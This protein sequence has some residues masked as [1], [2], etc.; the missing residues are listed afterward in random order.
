MQ[1]VRRVEELRESLTQVKAPCVLVPTMGA[2]HEG[3]LSLVRMARGFADATN[4]KVVVSIFVN[5]IQFDREDDLDA[6][7]RDFQRDEK[8][9]EGEG[10]DLVFYP[11]AATMYFEDASVWVDEDKL[12]LGF[13]GG[14]R[15]GQFRGVCTVVAKL[16]T[17]VQADRAVFG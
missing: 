13:C 15:P 9:C 17:L 4:R 6:Y 10:V 7:P 5:P 2:L 14:T 12:S 8:L 16:F 11:E 3:H 1:V